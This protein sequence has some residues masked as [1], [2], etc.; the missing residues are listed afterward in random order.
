MASLEKIGLP[1]L[2]GSDNYV[3]WS[4]RLKAALVKEDLFSSIEDDSDESKNNKGLAIIKL[5]CEDGPLLYIKDI[6]MAKEAWEKLENIYNPKGFT[7]EFLTLKEFFNTSLEDFDSM[8]EYLF[9]VKALVDDLKSKNIILPKQVVMA[10]VLNSLSAEYEGFI[11]NITQALRH[12]PNSYSTE[13]LFS[14]LIDEARGKENGNKLLFTQKEKK[15]QNKSYKKLG[16]GKYCQNCKLSSHMTESC[17]FLF[18]DKAP[19]GWRIQKNQKNHKNHKKQSQEALITSLSKIDTSNLLESQDN[20]ESSSDNHQINVIDD[21]HQANISDDLDNILNSDDLFNNTEVCLPCYKSPNKNAVTDNQLDDLVEKGNSSITFII[22]SAA[23]INTVYDIK[24]FYSYK[25]VNKTVNWGRAKTLKVKYQ[26]DIYIKYDTGHISHIKDVYYIPELG[27]NL[28]SIHKMPENIISFTGNEANLYNIKGEHI[29]AGHKRN[30]LYEL[31]ATALYPKENIYIIRDENTLYK[32]HIRLGHIGLIPLKIILDKKGIKIL[33]ED[34]QE[35]LNNKCRTCLLSKDNRK[36]YKESINPKDYGILDRIHSDLGGPLSPTYDNYKYYI[37]F[38]DKKSRYL[39]II[40][41]QNK[42]QVYQAFENFKV[43]IENNNNTHYIKEFFTDNG[44]EY[45]NKRFKIALNKYGI[46]HNTTP[47]YTKEPN[48]LIERINLTILNKV[49][50]FLI[51]SNSPK[52]LWGEAMLSAVYIYN[53]TPHKALQYKTPYEIYYN[54]KSDISNIKIWGSIAYYHTNI[55]KKKLLPRKEEAI[56]IGY[57]D[58]NHYKLWDLN[59]QRSLWSRDVEILEGSYNT[60]IK[61]NKNPEDN[62]EYMDLNNSNESPDKSIMEHSSQNENENSFR[63]ITRSIT[64]NSIYKSTPAHRVEVQIPQKNIY[65]HNT[66]LPVVEEDNR[67]LLTIK[68][69]ILDNALGSLDNEDKPADFLLTTINI[70][71]PNNFQEAMA[72]PE[73]EEWLRACKEEIY[74]LESQHTYEIVDI[75][76]DKIPLK[77]RWV[78]KKKPINNPNFIKRGHITNSQKTIRYKA[79]WVIQGFHQKLGVD[80][81][82]TFSPTCR[83][84]TWHILLI[85][86]INKNW[87]IIQFDVKNAFIHANIDAAIYTILPIGIYNDSNK[88]CLLKKALYGLKQAP[89]L[90]FKY[91]STALSKLGF[92]IFPYDEGIYINHNTS[93]III[94]HVD[95][96]LIIHK[97]MNYINEISNKAQEYI[98]I[99]KIGSVSTF[100]GNDISINYDNKTLFINQH[101]YTLKILERFNIYNNHKPAQIPGDPGIK[102][103]KNN[104]QAS[105]YDIHEYQKQIGSLLYLALKTRP[106]ITF[107]V[108]YCSRFMSNPD[109]EH[110]N[111]LNKIWKYLLAYPELGLIWDCSGDNLSIKGYSDSDWGNNLE[112][113]KSTSAYIFSLSGNIAYNNPISWTSQLQKSIALSS[114]EAEYMAL[115]EATKEA[116]YLS[117]MLDYFNNSLNLN[118]TVTIPKILVDSDSAKKLAENP[119]FHKRSK[120]IDI[121]YHFTRQAIIEGKINLIHIPSKYQLADLLTKNVNHLL[122]T[123]YISMARLGNNI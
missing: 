73:K 55:Y 74:E 19:K 116:I 91:L 13:N 5:L 106:D 86:A 87:Y 100:L 82:E 23:T 107:P 1:K 75:P 120:H 88:A 36:I 61:D 46:I 50:S 24:Y 21:N 44:K 65:N 111:A 2:R 119:E 34:Y 53:K 68:D 123:S 121:T 103:R 81:L 102:L 70:D 25:E 59:K 29:S 105:T 18:P 42:H 63:P 28:L 94:C 54:M 98:K 79:R 6:S 57:N 110:F 49:R 69:T 15:G 78:F 85:I 20:G 33:K 22:D 109:T 16:R 122:H 113:R 115:K 7:T 67:A 38:L 97:D 26:G 14:S 4:I 37:T 48:G 8:E 12:D 101:K 117:N 10:W 108:I 96:I 112:D 27:L 30:N 77:G 118:Y 95:D 51:A 39:W 62:Y 31:N 43:M 92:T 32:W 93:C 56:L 84:E 9:K 83:T 45:V 114:C 64:N 52:Y 60:Q 3:T 76:S 41:L 104:S 90:W 17:F 99:E 11:S 71:E 40:L 66:T 72:S 47:A 89:R 35:F 80:F 58:T